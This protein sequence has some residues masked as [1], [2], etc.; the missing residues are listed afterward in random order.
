[1]PVAP[2]LISAAIAVLAPGKPTP[3]ELEALFD[4]KAKYGAIPPGRQAGAINLA[5]YRARS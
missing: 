5:R 3:A 1:M 4:G 2:N